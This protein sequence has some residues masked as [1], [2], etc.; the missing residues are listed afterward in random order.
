MQSSPH[1]PSLPLMG[2]TEKQK[3]KKRTRENVPVHLACCSFLSFLEEVSGKC[4]YF[5]WESELVNAMD[6]INFRSFFLTDYPSQQSWPILKSY[7]IGFRIL[8][9]TNGLK[10]L[11]ETQHIC[12]QKGVQ[13]CFDQLDSP[14]I[15]LFWDHPSI[16][17]ILN[18]VALCFGNSKAKTTTREAYFCWLTKLILPVLTRVNFIP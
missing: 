12:E 13:A 4:L 9:P 14:P 11:I 10:Y 17:S 15:I 8:A 3:T 6:L 18:Q 7:A 16:N 2:K 1:R 5:T